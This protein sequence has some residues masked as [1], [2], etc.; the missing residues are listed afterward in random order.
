MH[1]GVCI[2]TILSSLDQWALQ[3]ATPNCHLR[4]SQMRS[5]HPPPLL[6]PRR[7]ATQ[8]PGIHCT[9]SV[10]SFQ[11]FYTTCTIV[12][13]ELRKILRHSFDVKNYVLSIYDVF[14]AFGVRQMLF[15]AHTAYFPSQIPPGA[16]IWISGL[17][18]EKH[19]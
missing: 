14:R 18:E 5:D 6:F 13:S 4:K 16:L 3:I 11:L 12:I 19:D 10:Y 7:A 17:I 9:Q 1:L 2:S 15:P 8:P